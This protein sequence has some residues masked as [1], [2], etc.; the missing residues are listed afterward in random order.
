MKEER[1]KKGEFGKETLMRKLKNLKVDFEENVDTLVQF[2]GLQSRVDIYFEISQEQIN[3]QQE[4]KA[5]K[6]ENNRLTLIP[7]EIEPETKATKTTGAVKKKTGKKTFLP[8]ILVNGESADQ[9]Q[10][11]MANCCNPVQGDDIFAYLAVSNGLKIHRTNCPNSTNLMAHYGY[12]IMKAEWIKTGNT[13]FVADLLLTGIDDGV[14][15]IER[16]SHNISSKLGF[17]IR[18]FNIEGKEGYFEAKISLL[19]QNKDQ[20]NI[21]I[22]GL[23]N[24]DGISS[25]IRQEN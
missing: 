10:Y 3:I 13:S 22:R 25:V 5:F 9:Y 24:I 12:R 20:L 21:A 4:L 14:G 1:R 19:V 2:F 18:S 11:S 17:N 23:R 15:V 6:I 7:P 16:L 8:K